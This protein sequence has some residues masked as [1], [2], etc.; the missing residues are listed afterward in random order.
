MTRRAYATPAPRSVGSFAQ[1]VGY[2]RPIVVR[3][4]GRTFVQRAS[5]AGVS[6]RARMSARVSV[7]TRSG[8]LQRY[9]QPSQSAVYQNVQRNT[10]QQLYLVQSNGG[11]PQPIAPRYE[12]YP[13]PRYQAYATPRAQHCDLEE[14]EVDPTDE[15]GHYHVSVGEYCE[16]E[17]E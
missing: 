1:P 4:N 13:T 9:I 16:I 2:A 5:T 3:G 6:A 12:P 17:H 7:A 14:A 8:L 10:R 15:S 11:A